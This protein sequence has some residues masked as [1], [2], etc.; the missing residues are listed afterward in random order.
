MKLT[1]LKKSIK[2][3]VTNDREWK[4]RSLFVK[5]EDEEV[6]RKIY[7]HLLAK[8]TS[9]QNIEKFIKPSTYEGN[10]SY[11]F[12]LNCS[13]Y[14]FEKV[15]N[16][17]EIDANVIFEVSEKGFINAKIQIIDR[18][19]QIHAYTPST[20][21]EADGWAFDYSEPGEQETTQKIDAFGIE[22][23]D[24]TNDLPF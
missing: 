17:G 18:K 8:K 23:K 24:F 4:I 15:E 22:G 11:A 12:G 20:Y 2:Q 1:I 19:E 14:T 16:F 7:A 21:Q 13:K 10:T 5:F 9:V 3:G 6:Y